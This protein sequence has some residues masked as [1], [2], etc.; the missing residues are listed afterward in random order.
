MVSNNA[1]EPL[2]KFLSELF[3]ELGWIAKI[4]VID[5]YVLR[6][7]RFYPTTNA[8]GRFALLEQGDDQDNR[9]HDP[10]DQECDG[11]G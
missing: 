8:V 5:V 3:R 4:L 1:F 2:G 9:N 7:D 10:E 6:D 11:R